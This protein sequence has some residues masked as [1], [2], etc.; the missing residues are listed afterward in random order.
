[1]NQRTAI[2]QILRNSR[3]VLI[4]CHLGPDGDCLG[5]GLALALALRRLGIA[6]T[7]A[8]ADGVPAG[9]GFLPG[10]RDVVASAPADAVFD[11]AVTVECSTLDRAGALEPAIRRA[12][13]IVAIDHHS[14]MPP[15][16]HLVDWDRGA[17][18]VG[19][20]VADLI[21]RLGVP[22]DAPISLC[23]QAALVTDTGVF[24]YSN[25]TPATLRLAADLA[26]RGAPIHLVVREVYEQQPASGLRLLGLALAGLTLHH[27]GAVAVTAITPEM[28]AAAGATPEM[29]TGIAGLLRTIVGVRLAMTFEAGGVRAD[30]VAQALGGGGHPVAAGADVPGSLEDVVRRALLLAAREIEAVC[31]D[32]S[33]TA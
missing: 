18:A 16:A 28:L 1:V 25:T 11:V 19:E 27:D 15:Y 33:T 8:S 6:A 22:L 26:E 9:L 21:A 5:S 4:A 3:A 13:T 20:Q 2:A 14:E 24:R 10:A 23:L 31:D 12:R 29:V 32:E 30:R 7:V 17:A